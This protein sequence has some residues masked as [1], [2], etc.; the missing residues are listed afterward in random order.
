VCF[1]PNFLPGEFCDG[2]KVSSSSQ[3]IINNINQFINPNSIQ[4]REVFQ[5]LRSSVRK[6]I[7]IIINILM[8]AVGKRKAKNQPCKSPSPDI[9][10]RNIIKN[11]S[12]ELDNIRA[13]IQQTQQK[14]FRFDL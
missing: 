7:K 11:T 14:A 12:I 3:S 10:N 1:R 2:E 13:K 4:Q 9:A 8:R 6:T 5:Y